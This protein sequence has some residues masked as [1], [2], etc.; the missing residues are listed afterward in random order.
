MDSS[1]EKVSTNGVTSEQS[2]TCDWSSHINGKQQKSLKCD[3]NDGLRTQ[4]PISTK[5]KR[6]TAN[7]KF[8]N[9]EFKDRHQWIEHERI[10]T[11]EK[12]ILCE[13]CGKTFA[14]LRNLVQHLE[15][16]H[17]GPFQCKYCDKTFARSSRLNEH[18]RVHTGE[19]P[20][21]CQFCNKSFAIFRKFKEH[22]RVHTGNKPFT[23]TCC[24][25][26]FATSSKLKRHTGGTRLVDFCKFCK[27]FF[28]VSSGNLA[29]HECIPVEAIFRCMFC[30][31]AFIG[32]DELKKHER[33]HTKEKPFKCEV[34]NTGFREIDHLEKHKLIHSKEKPVKCKFCGNGFTT[35]SSWDKGDESHS[36]IEVFTCLCNFCNYGFTWSGSVLK[37]RTEE[38]PFEYKCVSTVLSD[39]L[40]VHQGIQKI[41][42]IIETTTAECNSS[43]E[44]SSRADCSRKSIE[45]STRADCSRERIQP[46]VKPT[47]C[48]TLNEASTGSD[49][50]NVHER[51]HNVEKAFECMSS[52]KAS[53]DLEQDGIYVK[54]EPLEWDSLREASCN[55]NVH[56]RIHTEEATSEL[57]STNGAPT[58]HVGI[59]IKEEPFEYKSESEV[60]AVSDNST[61]VGSIR[62]AENP[63]DV[64][65]SNGG[66]ANDDI[67]IKEEPFEWESSPLSDNWNANQIS[68]TEEKHLLCNESFIRSDHL[69][70]HDYALTEEVSLGYMSSGEASV[71]HKEECKSE[72]Q[73]HLECESS[74]VASEVSDN[75]N[76]YDD[77][78]SKQNLQKPVDHLLCNKRF[79]RSDHLK[80][81]DYALMNTTSFECKYC[82]KCFTT[83]SDLK[84]HELKCTEKKALQC[85]YCNKGFE[86]AHNLKVHED[87][88]IKNTPLICPFCN[89]GFTAFV[90]MERHECIP[91]TEKPIECP[92]SNKCFTSHGI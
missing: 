74:S 30:D 88:H 73:E 84:K 65:S 5:K 13:L 28:A 23:C 26:R 3:K 45:A 81:H 18:E 64:R 59:D 60:S 86:H 40:K 37:D 24:N 48:E 11:G 10:H 87:I 77:I 80:E 38:K 16:V 61:V 44:A 56:E 71:E 34:C 46:E 39:S 78:Q 57:S 41:V 68:R 83:S 50:T 1:C 20:F 51:I 4:K 43:T 79:T 49:Y 90:D 67:D 76:V 35:S 22:Q 42:N 31:R 12:P 69:K 54:E 29:K 55:T 92:N 2:S 27:K 25:K 7:C 36:K 15:C 63:C 32:P 91:P 52:G 70:E 47:E 33:I 62:N 75:I 85:K 19:K 66:S 72:I 58:E 21:L 14:R 17:T 8:C 53:S 6:F 82:D 9:K 89:T